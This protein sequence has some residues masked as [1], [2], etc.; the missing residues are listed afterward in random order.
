MIFKN[1]V[2][3]GG[4][5]WGIAYQGVLSELQAQGAVDLKKLE[6]VAG[7]SAGAITACLISIGYTPEQLGSEIANKDFGDFQDESFGFGRDTARL[8]NE[9]GWY[10]GDEFKKWIRGLIRKKIR[11]ISKSAGISKPVTR[12]TFKELNAWHKALAR[13]GVK[14]PSLY[15]VGTN[16]SRQQREVY[17]HEAS[18]QPSLHIDDAVRRSMSIPLFFACARGKNKDVIVDGGLTWNYPINLFDDK[19][20]L[21][22]PK[23]G[24]S[25]SYAKRANQVFNTESLGFRLDTPAEIASNA[26]TWT[27]QAKDIDHLIN[28]FSALAGFVRA[29][30]N[31]SHLKSNDFSRT[32]VVDVGSEIG[33]T[34]F[35]MSNKE[36]DYLVKAGRAGVQRYLKWHRSKTGENDLSRIYTKMAG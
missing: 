5:V 32:V 6:R 17:S 23:F 36:K 8:I 19:K 12:P 16:L 13:K 24:K 33:F 35:K 21:S 29:M 18:H 31:K 26:G 11:E 27:N 1:L 9:Y 2:F 25:I 14:L 4:G 3:E 22:A 10:K 28:Y 30:A 20:Y 7:A 15:V 34:D